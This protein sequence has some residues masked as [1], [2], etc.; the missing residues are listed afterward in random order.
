M[1]N[2]PPPPTHFPDNGLQL[3]M[4]CHYPL[5]PLAIVLAPVPCM[6]QFDTTGWGG[7]GLSHLVMGGGGCSS[8]TKVVT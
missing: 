1:I 8:M 5:L 6:H 3:R 2:S 7:G 4:R